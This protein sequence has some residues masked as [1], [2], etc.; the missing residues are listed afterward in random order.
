MAMHPSSGCVTSPGGVVQPIPVQDSLDWEV[1][2]F[3][4]HDQL[5][6][7]EL[8]RGTRY[9]TTVRARTRLGLHLRMA[10]ATLRWR[11]R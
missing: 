6:R 10:V 2:N 7:A 11:S 4:G 3:A 1:Y 8:F 5:M 9:L